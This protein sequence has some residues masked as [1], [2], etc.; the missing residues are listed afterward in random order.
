MAAVLVNLSGFIRGCGTAETGINVESFDVSARPEF[1]DF[2]NDYAGEVKGFA[3]GPIMSEITI[4]GEYTGTGG[5]MFSNVGTAFVPS[6]TV[7]YF[8]QTVGGCYPDSMDVS[9][10]RDGFR[11]VTVKYTRNKGVT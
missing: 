6:N 10:S 3:V 9:N 7:D 2:L 1:K 8:F 5:V 11:R 4:S